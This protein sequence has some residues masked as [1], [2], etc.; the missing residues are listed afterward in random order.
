MTKAVLESGVFEGAEA[1]H[2]AAERAEDPHDL[3]RFADGAA[4][5]AAAGEGGSTDRRRRRPQL[6]PP[7]DRR[8]RNLPES[9]LAEAMR[10]L[11]E[12]E[13][14]FRRG[15]PP[16]ASYLFKHALVHDAACESLLKAKR[17]MLHGRLR[18]HR[19]TFEEAALRAA[20]LR[21]RCL[22]RRRGCGPIIGCRQ[23]LFAA[24]A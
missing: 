15:T 12:A 18:T 4:G 21:E 23:L 9:E 10:Q 16:D 2:L 6:R 5:S 11:V 24:Q 14:I 3:A 19:P 8:A 1:Y 20:R 13:L 17:V 7:N 22:A